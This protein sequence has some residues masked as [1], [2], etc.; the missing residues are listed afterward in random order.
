MPNEPST[1]VINQEW[2]RRCSDLIGSIMTHRVALWGMMLAMAAMLGAL[3]RPSW[4]E[5]QGFPVSPTIQLDGARKIGLGDMC[6]PPTGKSIRRSSGTFTITLNDGDVGR[7]PGDEKE[8]YGSAYRERVM[9]NGINYPKRGNSYRFSALVQF[10]ETTKSSDSTVFFEVHQWLTPQCS[11]YPIIMLY[12]MAD[13]TLEAET[14]SYSATKYLRHKIPGWHRSDFEGQWVEVAA[15]VSTVEG[16]QTARVYLGG[17]LVYDEP[18]LIYEAGA[19]RPHFG[20]Y[21]PGDPEHPNPTDRIFVRD[22]RVAE[23][24]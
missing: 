15:D 5:E 23:F 13:G 22:M 9:I 4:A 2:N 6:P 16:V 20:L 11:C 3:P 12:V 1:K 10:D 19:V 8:N 17:K 21:R 14:S 18:S 7:C 24:N